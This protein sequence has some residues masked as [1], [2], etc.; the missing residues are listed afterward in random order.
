MK[1]GLLMAFL[2]AAAVGYPIQPFGLAGPGEGTDQD[3]IYRSPHRDICRE[4]IS[5]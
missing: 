3:W 1:R 5:Q 4:F 2:I